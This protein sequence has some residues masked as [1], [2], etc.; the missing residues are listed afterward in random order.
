M[1]ENND[2]N[3]LELFDQQETDAEHRVRKLNRI[4]KFLT[5]TMLTSLV[6]VGVGGYGVIKD[7]HKQT[8]DITACEKVNPGQDQMCEDK[9]KT[10]ISERHEIELVAG[11]IGMIGSSIPLTLNSRSLSEAYS[12]KSEIYFERKK[13]L[14]AGTSV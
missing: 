4:R 12:D 2:T 14:E 5:V 1:P 10:D 13:F 9:Y 3:Q 6:S 11:M 8:T 7:S